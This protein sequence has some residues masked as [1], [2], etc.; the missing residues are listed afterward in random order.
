MIVESDYRGFRIEVVAVQVDGSWGAE[1]R[2]R[3]MPSEGRAHVGRLTCRDATAKVAEVR[4][5]RAARRWVDAYLTA[6]GL[7]LVA[8]T[9]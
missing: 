7:V 5:A 1:V 3:H 8:P 6:S 9:G 4:A 2:I